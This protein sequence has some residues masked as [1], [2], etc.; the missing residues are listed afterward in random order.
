[1]PLEQMA[2]VS[3]L[4]EEELN[5]AVQLLVTRSLL[6]IWGS[7]W[8]RRYNIHRLTDAFLRT[9]IIHLPEDDV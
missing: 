4:P 1:M 6:E 3:Q 5:E 8:Q 9:E 7:T 2:E